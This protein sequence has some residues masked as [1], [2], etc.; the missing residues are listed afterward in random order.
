MTRLAELLYIGELVRI[1]RGTRM[2]RIVDWLYFDRVNLGKITH[3][4][5]ERVDRPDV[6]TSAEISRL[7]PVRDEHLS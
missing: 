2:W 7:L 4:E 3:A 1:G 5:L 6:H